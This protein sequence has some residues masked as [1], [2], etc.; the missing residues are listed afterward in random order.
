[1]V[2]K[3]HHYRELR[4]RMVTFSG[5]KAISSQR[6]A[7]VISLSIIFLLLT[8]FVTL[9][10]TKSILLEQKIANNQARSALAFEA[11]EFGISTAVQYISDGPDRDVDGDGN[12]DGLMDAIFAVDAD[13][14]GTTNTSL[15]GAVVGKQQ[16]VTVTI[17]DI[18]TAPDTLLAFRIV[19]QG[20]SDDSSAT[21]TITQVIK[22]VDALPNVPDNPLT[23]R[24]TVDVNG[25]ATVHNPEGTSSIW[26]GGNVDIGSN[27]STATYVADPSGADYPICMDTPM[28]C[29]TVQTS[30]KVTVG[31]DIIEHDNNLANLT[32]EQMFENFFG[33]TPEAYREAIVTVDLA[34]G[35]DFSTGAGLAQ[36]EVVWYEGNADINGV[37]VGC[38]VAVNGGNVC[39]QANEAPSIV[40]INGD[41]NMKGGPHF[42]GIVFVMGDITLTGNSTFHGALVVA[43]E[44]NNTA[45]SL[46]VWYNSRLLKDS[47][48]NGG[49]SAASGAWHDF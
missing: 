8:T 39:A 9:Y 30:N 27:N 35:S 15:V 16:S 32:K 46:D 28:T 43:G 4:C 11:A 42:Y 2:I 19:S 3:S 23:A 48:G 17:T 40:I 24:G 45:G 10:T 22:V 41:V 12:S 7:I 14:V 33:M 1:M 26:S 44:S 31:L 34:S 38:S 29:S 20:F 21:R 25:S 49:F 47:R 18:T 6:G 36:N 13:N 5:C 37:T